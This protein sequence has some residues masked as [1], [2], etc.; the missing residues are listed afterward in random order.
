MLHEVV[1]LELENNPLY[2][3]TEIIW[4]QEVLYR[5]T[6]YELEN[7]LITAFRSGSDGVV[8]LTA[9]CDHVISC[10]VIFRCGA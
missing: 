10:H 5:V 8:Q 1:L 3:N 9:P 6:V 4:L 7:S 2:D